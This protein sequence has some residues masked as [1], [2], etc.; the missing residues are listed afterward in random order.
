MGLMM[1]CAQNTWGQERSVFW[2]HGLN[3]NVNSMNAYALYFGELY[4]INSKHPGHKSTMGIDYAA[5]QWTLDPT[6]KNFV[7]THSM[8]GLVARYYDQK[9]P[10]KRFGGLITIAAPHQGSEFASAFDNGKL[11]TFFESII[12]QGFVGYKTMSDAVETADYHREVIDALSSMMSQL[13]SIEGDSNLD[14]LFNKIF[15]LNNLLRIVNLF[16]NKSSVN[17]IASSLI[18]RAQGL[19]GMLMHLAAQ[20]VFAAQSGN[21]PNP[22]DELKPNSSIL[23]EINGKAFVGNADDGR[24]HTVNICCVSPNNPGLK[25]L[26]SRLYAA[27]KKEENLG[28]GQVQDDLLINFINAMNTTAWRCRELYA[29]RFRKGSWWS[30]GLSNDY[31]RTR[32]DAFERQA[33]FWTASNIESLYQ[34]CLAKYTTTHTETWGEWV[35]VG[36]GKP[37]P[38]PGLPPQTLESIGMDL[39][40]LETP[41]VDA[42][43][44]KVLKPVD[45][46]PSPI[47]PDEPFPGPIDGNGHWEWRTY[48][49]TYTTTH[50]HENDGIVTLPSQK[51][52]A[53]AKHTVV[54]YGTRA[55]GGGIDHEKAK[56]S[57]EVRDLIIELMDGKHD[58]WFYTKRR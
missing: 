48:S 8:G 11:K 39:I 29:E 1:L 55:D 50:V 12:N 10:D 49:R 34:N 54:L 24:Q 17:P 5:N 2:M 4:H 22:K 44:E 13:S 38:Q 3:G 33:N 57:N 25:F 56:R 32:R 45:E 31:Y 6:N 16:N 42:D 15:K 40:A 41:I 46:Y 52:W 18:E 21:Y 7:V 36:N 53:E 19:T 35:W 47:D 30:L 58:P 51:G 14:E 28:I 37:T 9:H 26:G 23:K 43:I 27:I 20:A